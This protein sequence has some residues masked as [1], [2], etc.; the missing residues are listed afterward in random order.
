MI[1]T[2]YWFLVILVEQAFLNRGHFEFTLDAASQEEARS[3]CVHAAF[4]IWRL[5][6]AYKTAFTLRH[7]HYGLFY[8]AYSA[9]LVMLQHA[10]EDHDNYIECIRFFWGVLS[11]YQR[12]HTSGLKK[13]FRVLKQLMH[14]VRSV[15]QQ[16]NV[17]GPEEITGS[18]P[19]SRWKSQ[20]PEF[21]VRGRTDTNMYY[22]TTASQAIGEPMIEHEAMCLNDMNMWT[23]PWPDAMAGESFFTD[24]S[25]FGF[26]T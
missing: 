25:L 11:D 8:A 13:P 23:D 1:S 12:G 16:I 15:T 18:R 22:V 26:F 10:R 17:D 2:T 9:V 20:D 21:Y 5:L 19:S 3:T 6:E 7:A 14:R 24:N 4:E